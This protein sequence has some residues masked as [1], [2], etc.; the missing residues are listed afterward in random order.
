MSWKDIMTKDRSTGSI[1]TGIINGL[2]SLLNGI[3]GG[4]IVVILQNCKEISFCGVFSC[5][6]LS[7]GLGV[8]TAVGFFIVLAAYVVSYFFTKE[9]K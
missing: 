5:L 7:G 2:A 9:T 4:C 3:V 8:F 6:K 1:A